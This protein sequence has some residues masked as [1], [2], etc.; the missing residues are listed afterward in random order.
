MLVVEPLEGLVL[1]MAP[2]S[3]QVL[4]EGIKERVDAIVSHGTSLN[5]ALKYVIHRCLQ[6]DRVFLGTSVGNLYVYS[7]DKGPGK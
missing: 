5:S 7:I 3:F 6:G 1:A 2:F 4:I